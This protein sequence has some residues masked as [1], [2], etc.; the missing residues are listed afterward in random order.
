MKKSLKVGLIAVVALTLAACAST[1][2][3]V[4]T[5]RDTSVTAPD[6]APSEKPY[7]GV[8][9]GQFALV[10]RSFADQPPLIPHNIDGFDIT[11]SSNDCLD[12]HISSDFKGKKMPMVSKSHLITQ[13]DAKADP[14][15]NMLRWQCNSCH[16]AQ[17]DAKPLVGNYF[18]TN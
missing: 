3:Q 15:L 17:V 10:E 12:C 8:N 16:V 18:Q 14:E 7:L 5:L 1:A 11:A 9:P 13:A 4:S 6:A 2:I